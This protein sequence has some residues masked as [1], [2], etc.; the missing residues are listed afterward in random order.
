M[1]TPPF[2]LQSKLPKGEAKGANT[3]KKA[4]T[5]DTRKEN[6]L[7][8]NPQLQAKGMALYILKRNTS[9]GPL[10]ESPKV[11][12]PCLKRYEGPSSCSSSSRPLPKS[13]K[14]WTTFCPLSKVNEEKPRTRTIILLKY[15]L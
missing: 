13:P 14:V 1:L 5:P 10:I 11:C 8:H 3:I 6:H 15:L 12:T 7:F 2:R 9:A 4:T